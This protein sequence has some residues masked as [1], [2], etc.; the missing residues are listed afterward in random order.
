MI[1]VVY[2]RGIYL[3]SCELWLDPQT[4]RPFAFVSHAYTTRGTHGGHHQR[5]ILTEATAR[6]IR[7]RLGSG[8]K[9]QHV[10]R[11]GEKRDF[12]SFRAT[13]LPGGNV[14]GS[15]QILI[16]QAGESLLYAGDF[17]LRGNVDPYPQDN[18][19]AKTLIMEAV[20]GHPQFRFPPPEKTLKKLVQ[21]CRESL[22]SDAIPIIL[23]F[24]LGK[25][26]MILT[27]LSEAGLPSMLH[28]SIWPMMRLYEEMGEKFP[29]YGSFDPSAASG[30][31]LLY[32][33]ATASALMLDRLTPR[34][35]ALITGRKINK[36]T[37]I[38]Y[39]CDDVFPLSDHADYDELMELVDRVKP[40]RVFTLQGHAGEFAQ[41][42]RRKGLEAWA[43]TG[44]NQLE[45]SL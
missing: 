16:E 31:V 38:R 19:S 29:S 18:T 6:L 28:G 40:S 17:K 3:P 44:G 9:I 27:A 4:T 8:G 43:L 15:S 5:T 32:P 22:A 36:K 21:F 34:R 24:S 33:L 39:Q 12:G 1:E 35:V 30:H 14:L 20:Y 45:L 7:A 37:K 11:F 2:D 13:L 25:A 10:L 42:L 26:H 23:G 41:D